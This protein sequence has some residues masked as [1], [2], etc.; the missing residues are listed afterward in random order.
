[1]IK[2]S[3]HMIKKKVVILTISPDAART[4]EQDLTS[5]FPEGTVEFLEEYVKRR[6]GDLL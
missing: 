6:I 1:M 4:Y 2:G 5:I 3:E